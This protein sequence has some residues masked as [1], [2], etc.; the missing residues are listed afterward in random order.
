MSAKRGSVGVAIPAYRRGHHL[1]AALDSLMRQTRRPSEIVVVDDCSPD[2]TGEVARS[3]ADRGVTYVRNAQNAGVPAN[4][5]NSLGRLT[6]DYIFILE[7]HDVLQPTFIE[8]C[9]GMLD[10][11]PEAVLAFTSIA[12]ID[13]AGTVIRENHFRL[14][15]VIP[16]RVL[17]RQLVGMPGAIFGLTAMIRRSALTGLEPYFDP[18][19]W[20]YADIYLWIRLALRG[21]AAHVPEALLQ[22]RVREAG[23]HLDGK[24]WESL[25]CVDRM[26]RDCWSLAFPRRDL[27]SLYRGLRYRITQDRVGLMQL[28][29]DRA[30]GHA[31]QFGAL[32]PAAQ[33]YFTPVGR[34]LAR[35]VCRTSPR[36]ARAVRAFY[37]RLIRAPF[38]GTRRLRSAT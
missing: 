38:V 12:E 32:S 2:N 17:A 29:S 28:M 27:P 30:R 8:R 3:Y 20:A 5:N 33:R 10:A 36:Q 14:P 16:S 19:Y 26:K 21:P 23:H 15:P 25:L 24:E 34:T 11:N 4:Y 37:Q 6:S 7:D 22:M 35:C 31:V 18:K 1:G 13:D 9:A